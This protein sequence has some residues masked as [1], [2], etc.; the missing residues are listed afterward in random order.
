MPHAY[1]LKART[2]NI[3]ARPFRRHGQDPIGRMLVN[4]YIGDYVDVVVDGSAHSGMPHKTYC[5]KTGRVFDIGKRSIGVIFNKRVRNNILPKRLH[6]RYEHIRKSRC[7]EEFLKRIRENDKRKI[8]AKK[9]KTHVDNR[10]QPAKPNDAHIVDL[11][12]STVEFINPKPWT[13]VY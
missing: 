10:R 3:F 9:N 6:V 2:R 5:G 7:H 12:K 11:K 13:Q 4:Y 1:G 8:E